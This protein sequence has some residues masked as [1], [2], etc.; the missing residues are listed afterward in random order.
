MAEG[1][2]QSGLEGTP[3]I[4]ALGLRWAALRGMLGSPLIEA[5]EQRGLRDEL[6]RELQSIEQDVA[7]VPAR[8][9]IEI[10]AKVDVARTA[11]RDGVA[12]SPPWLLALLESVQADLR[13]MASGASAVRSQ[14]NASRSFAPRPEP[15]GAAATGDPEAA[16]GS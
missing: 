5:E 7:S 12:D 11:L 16:H 1:R 10:S 2:N 9:A 4:S 6:L 8:T 3:S 14:P 15:V 13:A